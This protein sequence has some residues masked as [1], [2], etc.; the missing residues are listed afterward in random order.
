MTS[1][2]TDRLLK[3][4]EEFSIGLT[5]QLKCWEKKIFPFIHLMVE[6]TRGIQIEGSTII[7]FDKYP[8]YNNQE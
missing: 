1:Y 3:L 5:E 4:D 8:N 6:P 7:W 2:V